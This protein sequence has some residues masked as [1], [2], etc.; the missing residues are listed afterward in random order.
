MLVVRIDEHDDACPVL[1]DWQ[2]RG[3]RNLER[4]VLDLVRSDRHTGWE[5]RKPAPGK[6][7]FRTRGRDDGV[8]CL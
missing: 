4:D 8:A 7:V 1:A 5:A 3:W 2:V 6:V